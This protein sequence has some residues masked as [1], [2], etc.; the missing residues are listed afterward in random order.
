MDDE[1]FPTMDEC[2]SE[3]AR[4]RYR[5][6]QEYRAAE[7]ALYG[8]A[9]GVS[10]HDFINAKMDRVGECRKELAQFVGDLEATRIC[11]EVMSGIEPASSTT[12]TGTP[13]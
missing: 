12:A 11:V 9:A 6:D 3:V 1:H 13:S 10:R 4:L 7:L 8:F 5:I 2:K